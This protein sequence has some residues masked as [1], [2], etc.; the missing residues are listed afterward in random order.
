MQ[1]I[2]KLLKDEI[3]FDYS[4]DKKQHK[5]VKQKAYINIIA[6]NFEKYISFSTGK[7]IQFIDSFQFMSSF[8]QKERQMVTV[9]Y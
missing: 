5:F 9:K 2:G 3:V 8:T 1:K 7:H 6:N 4:L